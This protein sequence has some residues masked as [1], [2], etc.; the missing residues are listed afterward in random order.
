MEA[1]EAAA[2]GDGV[3]VA[4][5]AVVAVGDSVGPISADAREA[6]AAEGGIRPRVE[7]QLRKRVR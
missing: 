6:V 5:A 2:T 7:V 3:P 1:E 4:V